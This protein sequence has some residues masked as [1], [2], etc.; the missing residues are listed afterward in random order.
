MQHALSHERSAPDDRRLDGL[1]TTPLKPQVNPF[2]SHFRFCFVFLQHDLSDERGAPD[3][4]GIEGRRG[5]ASLLLVDDFVCLL[6]CAARVNPWWCS[7]CL[8]VWVTCFSFYVQ[9]AFFMSAMPLTMAGSTKVTTN[10]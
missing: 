6:F 9:H 2:L 3:H 7:C 8:S 1:N 10:P 4:G 5:A